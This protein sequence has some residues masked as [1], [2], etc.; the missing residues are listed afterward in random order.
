MHVVVGYHGLDNQCIVVRMANVM[1]VSFTEGDIFRLT[2]SLFGRPLVER[3]HGCNRPFPGLS[4]VAILGSS[5]LPSEVWSIED[6]FDFVGRS[7]LVL[8]L[9][10]LGAP[11]ADVVLEVPISNE[12]NLIL[13]G[14]A[15]FFGVADISVVSVVLA[16]VPFRAV[17]L[18]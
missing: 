1:R 9:A 4:D 8:V 5:R 13:Q 3:A 15:F 11:V 10:R 17:S 2:S 14:D 6:G 18:H 7:C 12:L 16:L